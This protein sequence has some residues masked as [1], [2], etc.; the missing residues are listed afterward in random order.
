MPKNDLLSRCRTLI[1]LVAASVALAS[2]SAC[3]QAPEEAESESGP[4][5]LEPIGGTDLNRVILT[6]AAARRLGIETSPVTNGWERDH[7]LVRDGTGALKRKI[8][9]YSAVLYDAT[10]V[11]WAY[12][13]PEPLEFVR[14][15]ISIDFIEG[16]RAVLTRGPPTG[17]KVVTVGASELFGSEFE[18]EE[19]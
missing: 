13:N 14:R 16:A 17:T 5:R 18:F 3:G 8:I 19:E 4:V 7:R 12:V 15:R 6:G 9:P 2:L 1:A 10:G 11:T